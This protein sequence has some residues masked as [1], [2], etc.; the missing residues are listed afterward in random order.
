VFLQLLFGRRSLADLRYAFPDAWANDE[1]TML[2][3]TLFPQQPSWIAN[4]V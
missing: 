3:E 4:L 1:A 2:L